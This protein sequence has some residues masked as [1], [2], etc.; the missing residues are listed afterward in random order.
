MLSYQR[1]QAKVALLKVRRV[2]DSQ[3][4]IKTPADVQRLRDALI[5]YC[6][7]HEGWPSGKPP[8]VQKD[9]AC[10]ISGLMHV[11]RC[12][13]FTADV[14][15]NESA[16]NRSV[17]WHLLPK[18]NPNNRLVIFNPGHV[19]DF[20]DPHYPCDARTID[21]LLA[22]RFSV[23]AMLMPQND[24]GGVCPHDSLFL[25]KYA[26]GSPFKL[27]L[28]PIAAYL[29]YLRTHSA[30]DSFPS[31]TNYHMVGLSGGGWTTTVYAAIDPTIE[32]SIPIAG[33]LPHYLRYEGYN[34]DA[35]QTWPD[36]Y[37]IAGYLDL[38]IMGSYG[39]GRRQIQVLNRRDD[40][41]FG[42]PQHRGPV[43]WEQSVRGYESRVT[44]AMEALQS[45]GQYRLYIDEAATRHEI[46]V[47]VQDN[48][49]SRELGT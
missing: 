41:C 48:V 21:A 14:R 36:F 38:H 42:E 29:D 39:K 26:A 40:C 32:I 35:E 7:G 45:P 2:D 20:N 12:D 18:A 16:S 6:W 24:D 30:R 47:N 33:T 11:G 22:Q 49:I 37:G 10:P 19:P 31:Y 43:P 5:R 13:A 17:A 9:A 28:E 34:D 3:I 25:H 27:F 4:R 23:V 44:I 1:R 15:I 46:S 8:V